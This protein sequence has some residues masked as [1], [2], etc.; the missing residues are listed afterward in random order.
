MAT[1][2]ANW[3]S[4]LAGNM[5][6]NSPLSYQTSQR[7]PSGAAPTPQGAA[8]TPQGAAGSIPP[9]GQGGAVDNE[10]NYYDNEGNL[11]DYPIYPLPPDVDFTDP[12]DSFSY[13]P[14]SG[15]MDND[16]I[17]DFEDPYPYQD[18]HPDPS[19]PSSGTDPAAPPE[20]PDLPPGHADALTGDLPD[21]LTGQ[22]IVEQEQQMLGGDE[23]WYEKYMGGEDGYEF[24]DGTFTDSSGQTFSGKDDQGRYFI[25]VHATS[26]PYGSTDPLPGS[27]IG[28]DGMWYAPMYVDKSNFPGVFG[29]GDKYMPEVPTGLPDPD[30]IWESIKDS[31]P[32]P[33][34]IVKPEDIPPYDPGGEDT[35]GGDDGPDPDPNFPWYGSAPLFGAREIQEDDLLENLMKQ[36][37]IEDILHMTG[38]DIDYWLEGREG[39]KRKEY[40]IGQGGFI[41][42]QAGSLRHLPIDLAVTGFSPGHGPS[43]W[44][45]GGYGNY[46]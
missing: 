9:P 30:E 14:E 40:T 35:G 44:P 5:Q 21:A 6:A 2:L 31:L 20:V 23:Y 32:D 27:Y 37:D 38:G 36:G 39:S 24:S 45:D 41:P 18:Q 22:Q 19:D 10:G 33:D 43:T 1:A 12:P 46:S 26:P 42:G 3:F 15:D 29:T 34:S 11:Q 16:G 13:T 28:E 17:A 7:A 8:P 25:G 4:N